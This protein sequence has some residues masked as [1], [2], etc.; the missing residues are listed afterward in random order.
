MRRTRSAAIA[1]VIALAGAPALSACQTFSALQPGASL[2]LRAAQAL[3]VAE[4]AFNGASAGLDQATAQGL[5]KG[6]DAAS[7]R[8]LYDKAHEAL[9]AARLAEKTGDYASELARASDAIAGSGRI[10]AMA[11]R[12]TPT[13]STTGQTP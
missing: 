5:L 13:S 8:G 11:S 4:A 6:Q 2:K 12:S 3:Y 9:L 10:Q 7:A 1:A